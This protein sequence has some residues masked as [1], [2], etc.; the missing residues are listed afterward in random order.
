MTILIVTLRVQ[1]NINGQGIWEVSIPY[2]I[3]SCKICHK[4]DGLSFLFFS[5]GDFCGKKKDWWV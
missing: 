1:Y 4:Y 5:S 2:R 3:K